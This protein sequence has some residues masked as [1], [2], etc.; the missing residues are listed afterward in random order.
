MSA[1]CSLRHSILLEGETEGGRGYVNHQMWV[2]I[3]LFIYLFLVKDVIFFFLS[4]EIYIGLATQSCCLSCW[5]INNGWAA[6]RGQGQRTACVWESAAATIHCLKWGRWEGSGDGCKWRTREGGGGVRLEAV[7]RFTRDL[8]SSL[9]K[10]WERK[11]W[12]KYKMWLSRCF[13]HEDNR[14]LK[15]QSW[16]AGTLMRFTIHREQLDKELFSPFG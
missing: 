15:M 9:H 5:E 16:L 2:F 3:Y 7:V 6:Q 14:V 11:W 13:N 4:E 8:S 1:N 12:N 10:T